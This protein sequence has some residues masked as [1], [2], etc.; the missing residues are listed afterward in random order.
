MNVQSIKNF[1]S[2]IL[3]ILFCL[4]VIVNAQVKEI[5][6]VLMEGPNVKSQLLAFNVDTQKKTLTLWGSEATD[7]IFAPKY[8]KISKL[9]DE[10]LPYEED[11]QKSMLRAIGNTPDDKLAKQWIFKFDRVNSIITTE[12]KGGPMRGVWRGKCKVIDRANKF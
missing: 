8:G 6:C 5:Q 2:L 12:L 9:F 1:K 7:T 11:D 4:P 10:A 3:S